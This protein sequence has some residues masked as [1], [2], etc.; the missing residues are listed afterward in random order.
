MANH[1][2]KVS[3]QLMREDKKDEY[4]ILVFVSPN[5]A[6]SSMLTMISVRLLYLMTISIILT[7]YF[8]IM[9]KR[10]V[11]S[12]CSFSSLKPNW[13]IYSIRERRLHHSIE[14]DMLNHCT[15]TSM[16]IMNIT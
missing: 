10:L 4:M 9:S 11:S 3:S 2:F 14:V 1:K 6:A 12:L 7:C 15:L 13:E 8:R 16:H 5:L